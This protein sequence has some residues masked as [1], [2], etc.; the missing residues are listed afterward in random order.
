MACLKSVSC[1]SLLATLAYC[2]YLF[3]PALGSS[4]TLSL[5]RD[6]PYHTFAL[7]NAL[8]MAPTAVKNASVPAF[9]DI[10][11]VSLLV[12]EELIFGNC[13]L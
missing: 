4:V 12:S 2:V 6:H 5:Q 13:E 9:G 8:H 3:E 10:W 11:P 1:L 7:P